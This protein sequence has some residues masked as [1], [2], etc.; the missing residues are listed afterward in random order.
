MLDRVGAVVLSVLTATTMWACGARTELAAPFVPSDDGSTGDG[1]T[2]DG[3]CPF[4][5]V[6]VLAAGSQQNIDVRLDG[7]NVYWNDGAHIQRVKKSGGAVT[8]VADG[9]ID[10]GSF[11]VASSGVYFTTHGSSDVMRAGGDKV[12]TLPGPIQ[13]VTASANAVYVV[14]PGGAALGLYSVPLGGGSFT[15]VSSLSVPSP[16]P[17]PDGAYG[18]VVRNE[19]AYLSLIGFGPNASQIVAVDLASGSINELSSATLSLPPTSLAVDDEYVYFAE[20]IAANALPAI[21]LVPIAGGLHTEPVVVLQTYCT[22]C[23]F[24]A[25]LAVDDT[26]VYFANDEFGTTLDSWGKEGDAGVFAPGSAKQAPISG[27]ATDGVCVYWVAQG[28]ANVYAAP[29]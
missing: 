19:V 13:L 2:A 4:S 20:F 26:N 29:K 22:S 8:A 17:A 14:A 28:D 10:V 12:A 18:L 1:S 16:T 9:T 23:P 6:T 3:G 27:I 7:E 25:P 24:P 5:S 11:D 21:R 15:L